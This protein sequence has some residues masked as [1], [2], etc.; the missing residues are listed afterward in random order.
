MW[1]N[2]VHSDELKVMAIG[3]MSPLFR[4][5]ITEFE[6]QIEGRTHHL[7]YHR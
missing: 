2:P 7:R 3:A 1:A 4:Q 5:L 6:N